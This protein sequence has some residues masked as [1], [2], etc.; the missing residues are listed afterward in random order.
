MEL[1]KY[2]RWK[3]QA[4]GDGDPALVWESLARNQVPFSCLR[5][6]MA[7]GPDDDLAAPELCTSARACFVR[8]PI[9]GSARG[10]DVA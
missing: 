1:C 5:T 9:S 8:D 7:W 6:C 10:P 2:L 3:T 4:R